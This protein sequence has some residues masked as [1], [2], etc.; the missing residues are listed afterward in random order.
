MQGTFEE[1]KS[2]IASK[3][4]QVQNGD[5]E[6]EGKKHL[7]VY[8]EDGDQ[9]GKRP[10]II[11]LPEWWGL[12]DYVKTRAEMLAGLGYAAMAVDVF[13]EGAIANNPA[14]AMALTSPY[15]GDPNLVTR[16]VEAAVEKLKS[17]PDVDGNNIAVLG[18]CFGGFSAITAATHGAGVKAAVG[19]HP[20][21]GGITPDTGI[22]AKV[23]VCHGMSDEFEKDN[24]APFKAKMDSA[25]ISYVF[26]EYADAKHGF[27]S[28]E[29]DHNG[30]EF[31][32]PVAYNA[33]AD[34]ASWADMTE[35][36]HSVFK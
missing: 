36:L 1:L 12:N 21:L 34:S 17:Y 35:F 14:E 26:K 5:F 24:E 33:S 3:N 6:F 31:G 11:V 9:Q 4:I 25:G 2:Q 27:T 13:G 7:V 23:L 22:Q 15:G 29:A 32:I 28:P 16:L 19:F 8:A 10:G 20:S 18:F 30:K